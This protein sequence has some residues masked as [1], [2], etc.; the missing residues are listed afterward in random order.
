VN[1]TCSRKMPGDYWFLQTITLI[2][3]L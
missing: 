2:I 3:I 1:A